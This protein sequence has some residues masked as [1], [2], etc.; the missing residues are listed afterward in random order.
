M[1]LS[2]F[3]IWMLLLSKPPERISFLPVVSDKIPRIQQFEATITEAAFAHLEGIHALVMPG[4]S[5]VRG[6]LTGEGL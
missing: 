1:L 4:C 2:T 3:S 6:L 5:L